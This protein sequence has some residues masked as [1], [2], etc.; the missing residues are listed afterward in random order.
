[1]NNLKIGVRLRLAFG[2]ML[3]LLL[4]IAYIGWSALAEARLRMDVVVN[5]NNAKIKLSN[6][7]QSEL[8][9]VARSVRNYI[10]YPDPEMRGKMQRRID[11]AQKN[12]NASMERLGALIGDQQGKQLYGQLQTLAPETLRLLG[13]VQVLVNDGKAADAPAFLLSSVQKQQDGTFALVNELIALQEKQNAE[14]VNEIHDD[15]AFAVRFLIGATLLAAALA[16]TLAVLITRSITQPIDNAVMVAQ[17]VAAGDLT[18]HVAVHGRDEASQLLTALQ[19]MTT[20]LAAIVGQVRAGTDTIGTAS[21]EIASGNQDLSSRTEEQ[22]SSLEETASSM[23]ELTSTVKQSADNARQANGLAQS[24]SEVALRGG[25]VVSQVVETMGSINDSSRRIVD[26]ISVID[27]IAFQTNI[28]ALNAAVEA[29]RAGEQGRGF[30]VVAS[31]VRTLAQRSAAAAKEIK[32]LI[33]DSVVKVDAGAKL[34]DQAGTTMGEIVDSVRRV[35]DIMTEIA[36]ASQEQNVGIEQINQ[37]I[38]QMDQVT[39]QNAALV[40][41]SAAAAESMQQQALHL[42]RAVDVFKLADGA[43]TRP[44]PVSKPSASRAGVKRLAV[45]VASAKAVGADGWQAF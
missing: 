3:A 37:A 15:Y 2:A 39:Q 45:G 8:N 40:E 12:F 10:L 36:L 38:A 16:A 1:M 14:M 43:A 34:V 42:A 9:L 32:A 27:G 30:A 29:A 18:R 35:T 11:G 4:V 25:H 31:E 41:Q 5:E 19:T 22:A 6:T 20:S 26:I 28:L 21:R 44:A 13:Q 23:E 17:A 24:A 33:D 7:L